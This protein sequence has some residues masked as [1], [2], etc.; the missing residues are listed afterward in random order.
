MTLHVNIKKC[1]IF[2][3]IACSISAVCFYL[4]TC[5]KKK[6]L[7][8]LNM[9]PVGGGYKQIILES[10]GIKPFKTLEEWENAGKS[11]KKSE[12]VLLG[13]YQ[14]EDPTINGSILN[15]LG[16]VG[17]EKSIPFLLQ[18]AIDKKRFWG[19]RNT[20]LNSIAMISDRG[21]H[22][23]D[24]VVNEL[25]SVILSDDEEDIRVKTCA[26]FTLSVI[27]DPNAIPFIEEALKSPNLQEQ[28][29]RFLLNDLKYL[30]NKH[31]DSNSNLK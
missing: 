1:L 18:I 6:V 8:W 10:K 17:T 19:D 23:K 28:D 4:A 13:L 30:R 11:I 2:I 12:N 26:T 31:L 22:V 7:K 24:I 15:A 20:A 9:Y 29:K 16:H 27:G 25:C 3:L 5:N 21:F 14:Y